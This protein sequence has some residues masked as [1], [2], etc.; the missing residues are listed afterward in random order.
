VEK[1]KEDINNVLKNHDRERTVLLSLFESLKLRINDNN[2]FSIRDFL[3]GA[4]VA[5]LINYIPNIIKFI[6]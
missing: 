2:N 4:S 5:T 3:F 1:F 6:Y